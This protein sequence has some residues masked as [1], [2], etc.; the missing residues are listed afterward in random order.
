M[1]SLT[2]RLIGSQQDADDLI[3]ALHDVEG[4]E[5]V[6]QIAELMPQV[7]EDILPGLCSIEIE[8]PEDAGVTRRVRE[9]ANAQAQQHGVSM[10]VIDPGERSAP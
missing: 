10:E 7:E 3:A 1:P 2:L 9:V 4:V 8:V 6:A 5:H